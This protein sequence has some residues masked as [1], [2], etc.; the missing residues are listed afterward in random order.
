MT[1]KTAEATSKQAKLVHLRVESPAFGMEGPEK[2]L[3]YGINKGSTFKR[4]QQRPPSDLSRTRRRV[5]SWLN[6]SS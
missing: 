3:E 2:S 6:L 5:S 4:S 1:F